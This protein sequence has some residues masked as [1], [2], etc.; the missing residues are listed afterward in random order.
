MA[1]MGKKTTASGGNKPL[2]TGGK[3][4]TGGT[5]TGLQATTVT[6]GKKSGMQHTMNVAVSKGGK[7]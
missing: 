1:K 4:K 3:M 5:Q 6:G 2:T 7:K